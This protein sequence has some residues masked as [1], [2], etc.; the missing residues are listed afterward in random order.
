MRNKTSWKYFVSVQLLTV[1]LVRSVGAQNLTQH[2]DP[3]IG[4]DCGGTYP[5][6]ALPF[7]MVQWGPDT[8]VHNS[9]GGSYHWP[10]S[11]IMDFSITHLSGAGCNNKGDIPFLPV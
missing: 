1:L 3:F 4:T 2:V 11:L 5:G 7:G 10:D 8:T 6:A 9:Y